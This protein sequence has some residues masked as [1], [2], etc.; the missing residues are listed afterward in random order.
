MEL[1]HLRYFIAVAEELHFSRAAQR[2]HIAQPPLS[3]QIQHLEQ[4]L[5][6][7]LLIRTKRSVQ[8][9]PAGQV[10]LLEA[11]KVVAQ[12]ER[13]VEAAQQAHQGL[14]GRLEIGVVSAAMTEALPTILQVFHIRFPLVEIKLH[15]QATVEQLQALHERQI[16]VGLLHPPLQD[17][18]LKL[19]IIQREPLVVVLPA[20]HPLASQES[21]LMEQLREEAF[22]LY[23]RAWNPGTFDQIASLCRDAGF[24]MRAGQEAVGMQS[25]TSLVAAGFGISIVPISTQLLRSAGVVYRSLQGVAPTMDLAVAWRHDALSPVVHN[26]VAVAREFASY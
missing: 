14:R 17:V 25:I 26:F 9:T 19:E 3:Q 22:V 21:I 12:V 13:A 24:T 10:F 8:L 23:P 16:D 4:E 2:L 15:S 18:S 6:V 5:G 11:K 20:E 1:R 7:P